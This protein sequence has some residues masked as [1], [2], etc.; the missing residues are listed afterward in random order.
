MTLT[1]TEPEFEVADRKQQLK[2]GKVSRFVL[3]TK[4]LCCSWLFVMSFQMCLMSTTNEYKSV[5]KPEW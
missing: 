2:T 5:W 4:S 1:I 3:A